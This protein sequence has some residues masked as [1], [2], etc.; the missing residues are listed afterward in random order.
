M[1][2]TLPRVHEHWSATIG[3]VLLASPF[4]FLTIAV[5]EHYLGITTLSPFM[6][7]MSSPSMNLILPLVFLGGLTVA[8]ALNTYALLGVRIRKEG[9]TLMSMIALIPRTWNVVVVLLSGSVLTILLGY[10]IVENIG[11]A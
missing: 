6:D 8:L 5:Y 3:F 10:A 4:A 1:N 9:G 11:H 7:W 2:V